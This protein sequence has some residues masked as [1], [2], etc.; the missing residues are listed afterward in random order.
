MEFR[1]TVLLAGKTAT[2]LVVPADVV[3]ALGAGARA[4][5][6]VTLA[7]YSYPSTLAVMGGQHLIPLAAEHRTAAGVSAG[8][9]VL[10]DLVVDTAPRTVELP[11]ELAEVLDASQ[12]AAFAALSPSRQKAHV[13][14][15]GSAKTPETRARRIA[16]VAVALSA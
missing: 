4:P 14:S 5:V 2:G 7:G 15:V 8:D 3:E 10:V 13:V 16:A 12:R 9:D 1:S 6:T 11:A